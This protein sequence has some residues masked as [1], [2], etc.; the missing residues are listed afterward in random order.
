MSMEELPPPLLVEILTFLRHA[1]SRARSVSRA[2]HKATVDLETCELFLRLYAARSFSNAF[3]L[4]HHATFVRGLPLRRFIEGPGALLCVMQ[5]I[6]KYENE[7]ERHPDFSEL[8]SDAY[9]FDMWRAE[10]Q[11]KLNTC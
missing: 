1:V 7:L 4:N 5:R 2:M 3:W 9:Y 10:L 11:A 8:T 6:S